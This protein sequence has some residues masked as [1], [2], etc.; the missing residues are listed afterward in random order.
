MSAAFAIPATCPLY[1]QFRKDCG[2]SEPTLTATS[3]VAVACA[4]AMLRHC[5]SGLD[6]DVE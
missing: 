5:S 3:G 4:A 6:D 1:L 2:I